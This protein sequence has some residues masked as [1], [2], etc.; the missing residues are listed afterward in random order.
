MT[1]KIGSLK[2]VFEGKSEFDNL[3]ITQKD[4]CIQNTLLS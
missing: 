1:L 4:I 2:E 3:I